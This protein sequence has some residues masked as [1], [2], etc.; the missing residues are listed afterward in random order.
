[1]REE[2]KSDW[3]KE[4]KA[5]AKEI[6]DGGD[7]PYVDVMPDSDALDQ[8]AK[9]KKK[10]KKNNQN[11]NYNNKKKAEEKADHDKN[12]QQEEETQKKKTRTN[13]NE[14]KDCVTGHKKHE[15]DGR[16]S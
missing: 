7:H 3:R 5:D 13:K 14:K 1:M 10:E 4:V 6:A 15:G 9:N 11:T 12:K 2:Q 8:V 16:T